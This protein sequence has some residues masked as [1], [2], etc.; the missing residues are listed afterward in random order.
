MQLASDPERSPRNMS[1]GHFLLTPRGNFQLLR[2][3]HLR[4]NEIGC[5][6]LRPC[7]SYTVRNN[8]GCLLRWL[9]QRGDCREIETWNWSVGIE[10]DAI[11]P[12]PLG[13]YANDGR[14][15]VRRRLGDRQGRQASVGDEEQR[16]QYAADPEK[17]SC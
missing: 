2:S 7:F 11:G 17:V 1:A 12:F 5:F 3:R 6:H 4:L 13:V 8:G 9:F 14:R 10:H 16:E 15:N